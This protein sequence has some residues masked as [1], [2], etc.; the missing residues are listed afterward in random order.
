MLKAGLTTEGS[1]AASSLPFAI[2]SEARA[3]GSTLNLNDCFS[4]KKWSLRDDCHFR[5][6][7]AGYFASRQS[8]KVVF[9]PA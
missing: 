8:D 7:E 1:D 6:P 5:K 4:R 9:D 2:R 3:L